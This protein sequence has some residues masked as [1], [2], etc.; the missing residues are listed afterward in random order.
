MKKTRVDIRRIRSFF[1]NAV[2]LF[3][4][5]FAAAAYQSRNMLATDG[6]RAPE[7]RGMTLAG[8]P[9]D[10]HKHGLKTLIKAVTYHQ[11]TIVEA[12]GAWTARV[13]PSWVVGG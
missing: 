3:A 10:L 5:F 2:L 13:R 7:L 1:L 6:Q 4:V 9:Y 12:G 8:E 11:L